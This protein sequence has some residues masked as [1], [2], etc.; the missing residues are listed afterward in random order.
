MKWFCA[1]LLYSTF[2]VVVVLARLRYGQRRRSATDKTR[3]WIAEQS[4]LHGIIL[5]A[6]F[7]LPTR[8]SVMDARLAFCYS[9]ARRPC[10]LLVDNVGFVAYVRSLRVIKTK[11]DSGFKYINDLGYRMYVVTGLLLLCNE[12]RIFYST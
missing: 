11:G 4:V 6:I 2:G 12:Y 8:L 10:V 5:W 3:H 7:S 1:K 9:I